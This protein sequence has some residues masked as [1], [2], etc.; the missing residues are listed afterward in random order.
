MTALLASACVIYLARIL[1]VLLRLLS[2]EWSSLGAVV[3][4]G[5]SVLAI[6]GLAAL[7]RSANRRSRR[8]TGV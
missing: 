1:A 2:A 7:V 3:T 6:A 8:N 5:T 4:V